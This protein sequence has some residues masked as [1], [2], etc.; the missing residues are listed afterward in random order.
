MPKEREPGVCQ[1]LRI[2]N[3]P[4]SAFRHPPSGGLSLVELLVVIAIIGILMGLLLPAIQS[5]RE[6]ARR[7]TCLS[8]QSQLALAM[9]HFE[10]AQGHFPAGSIAQADPTD[11]A[12]PHTFYRW[13]AFAQVLP[14]LEQANLRDQL[15]ISLPMYRKDFSSPEENAAA[16]AQMVPLFLCP[17]DRGQRVHVSFGP[18][19]YVVCAGS[20][21]DGGS[22]L[23]AD[24]VF[25]INSYLQ[26][27]EIADGVSR[28]MLLSEALLGDGLTP[29][30]PRAE[31]DSRFAYTFAAAAPLKQS[32]CDASLLF[33]FTDPP[34]FAWAN[35]EFR[36]SMYNHYRSPNS[37]EFDCVSALLLA[38]I[39]E[40]YAAFGWRSAR[41]L[42]PGGVN[43]AMVD[44]SVRF[45]SDDVDPMVWRA[46]STRHGEEVPAQD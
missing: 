22:P 45:F 2:A 36:S 1:H 7:S 3:R 25:Y 14:H 24:G 5:A 10:S 34:G 26:L 33:N 15:D 39:S 42:H 12:T 28:T 9:H 31:V 23:V 6:S 40:R 43:G 4:P 18:T 13:S 46:L 41:S 32:A 30:T 29:F 11:P 8:R 21:N 35:G 38:P 19:N 37:V 17:S 20:G 16:V 44:C 27:A